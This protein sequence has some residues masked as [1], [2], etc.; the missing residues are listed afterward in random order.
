M[1]IELETKIKQAQIASS[2]TTNKAQ[3]DASSLLQSNVAT[4]ES[5]YK[6]QLQQANAL[7]AV[8]K[9]LGLSNAQL[10]TYLRAKILKEYPETKMIIGLD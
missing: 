1:A 10:L 7:A 2:I 4:S 5:F 8:K 6:I 3:G 9:S